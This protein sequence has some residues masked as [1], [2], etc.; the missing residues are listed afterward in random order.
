MV[1]HLQDWSSQAR[2]LTVW[3]IAKN[4]Y[5]VRRKDHTTILF[6]SGASTV[7]RVSLQMPPQ[8]CVRN[9]M[10]TRPF[11]SMKF[12]GKFNLVE[13]RT[14]WEV[15]LLDATFMIS[16]LPLCYRDCQHSPC[17]LV[18]RSV[19]AWGSCS[20]LIRANHS[21]SPYLGT[22]FARGFKSPFETLIGQINCLG[23]KYISTTNLN[24][25]HEFWSRQIFHG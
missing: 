7:S 3:I 11:R 18:S 13:F 22:L 8:Q 4:H 1:E 24:L 12:R 6:P 20:I 2:V 17:V 23:T 16:R 9:G 25:S 14:I 21:P 19:P 15:V 5:P 10:S